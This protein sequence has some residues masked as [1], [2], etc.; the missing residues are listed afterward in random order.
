MGAVQRLCSRGVLI[1]NGTVSSIGD[2][3]NVIDYYLTI[4]QE[5]EGL[6][7]EN[8]TNRNGTGEVIV[9]DIRVLDAETRSE[10]SK[11]IAG[12]DIILEVAYKSLKEQANI[13][14]FNLGIGIFDRNGNFM[15]VLNNQMA[16]SKFENLPASGVVHCYVPKFPLMHGSF[17]LRTTLFVHK[18][19]TDQVQ[20]ALAIT[21]EEGDYYNSGVSNV[22][23]RQ[24][25]YIPQSWKFYHKNENRKIKQSANTV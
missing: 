24:G 16:N 6:K 23:S 4:P 8:K 18:V 12:Q 25:I 19:L 1:E 10:I 2:V 21:V 11:I 9:S 20:N 15:S 7:L 3:E 14:D 13:K 17:D 5:E 22:Y